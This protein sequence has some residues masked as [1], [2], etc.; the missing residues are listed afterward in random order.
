MDTVP[1]SPWAWVIILLFIAAFFAVS[2]TAIASANRNKLRVASERGD[3]RADRALF[4]LDNFDRAI[5]TILICTN[6]VHIAAAAVVTVY[7]SARYGTGMVSIST[8]IMTVLVFFFG[9]MLPKSIA[10]K[11][12]NRLTLSNSGIIIFLMKVLT[13][14]SFVLAKIGGL[15]SRLTK[16]EQELTVTEDEL[17]DII[18]DMT[19][20]GTLEED[21]GEL[22]QSAIEFGDI[23][24][25]TIMTPIDKVEAVNAEDSAEDILEHIKSQVH[26][27][28]PVYSGDL[29]H[30]IG[31]L[32]IR[33]YIRAYLTDKNDL[34]IR[35]LLNKPLFISQDLNID[36][37]LPIMAEHQ[38][39]LAVAHDGHGHS[40]GVVSVEDILE[41]LVGEIWDE[42]D[43]DKGGETL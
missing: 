28:L 34:D 9:E 13:P 18:E 25:K 15:A 17:H 5:T 3:S 11:Y 16:A 4:V 35:K 33:N 27:R 37:L 24:V 21:E 36:D 29:N 23:T 12:A 43:K 26:S 6:I 40:T 1:R 7:V 2:E 14:L 41:E 39:T 8:L 10:K 20:E 42:D 19:E 32:Q 22:I 30:I 38:F 31:I